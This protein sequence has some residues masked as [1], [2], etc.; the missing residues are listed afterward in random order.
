MLVLTTLDR[1]TTTIWYLAYG[2]NLSA[3]KFIHDRKIQPL[4]A[5][6]VAVPGYVLD[7]NSAGVPYSE[8]A[9][10]SISPVGNTMQEKLAQLIGTSYLLTPDMYAKVIASEGGGIAYKEIEVT[11]ETLPD[12]VTPTSGPEVQSEVT[13][14]P[15]T[16]RT[17]VTLLPRRARPSARYMVSLQACILQVP[18]SGTHIH[19]STL[20]SAENFRLPTGLVMYRRKGSSYA[21]LLSELF[22]K[23]T[24]V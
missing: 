13:T 6:C 11:A 17:L 14:S 10:A 24:D 2:S 22:G 18:S 7:M 1:P 20:T 12:M 21:V 4:K 5:I 15:M 19:L 16:V 9:F 23:H 8:P 3:Q